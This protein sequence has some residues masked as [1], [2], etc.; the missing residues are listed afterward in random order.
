MQFSQLEVKIDDISRM[1]AIR[2][3]AEEIVQRN[4]R[5][6]FPNDDYDFVAGPWA[7]QGLHFAVDL[8]QLI[9]PELMREPVGTPMTL[10]DVGAGPGFGAA[11][12]RRLFG[13]GHYGP[14]LQ[15]SVLELSTQW[16]RFYPFLHDGLPV[17]VRNL[18][19][20]E[21]NSFDIVSSSH[22]IEH[23]PRDEAPLFVQKMVSV[24][25]K[26]TAV[27]CPW[28]EG[29]QR[30]PSHVYSVESDLVDD[31][32][33]DVVSIFPSFGWRHEKGCL[34]MIFRKG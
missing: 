19:E 23:L 11:F 31:L 26:F 17:A 34:G 10:L 24:S 27:I 28:K 18:Y 16:Q 14:K 30:H 21:D 9:K 6:I 8:L 7:T 20:V 4:F 15:V 25:R 22:V 2:K 3:E 32:K 13:E 33:P 29:K 5:E 1:T 12:F